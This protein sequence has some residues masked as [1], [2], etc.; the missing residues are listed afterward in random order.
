M[1]LLL[2]TEWGS[3]SGLKADPAPA[4]RSSPT[5]AGPKPTAPENANAPTGLSGG[6]T[7]VRAFG[8]PQIP[9]PNPEGVRSK[10]ADGLNSAGKTA[11][12]DVAIVA[13]LFANYVEV[14]RKHPVGA[15]PEITAALAGDNVRGL[16][17]LPP[18]HPAVNR[19]GELVDRWGTPYFFHHVSRE[20]MEIRSAGPD[21]RHFTADDLVWPKTE[22]T[23]TP[24]EI[25]KAEHAR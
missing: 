6:P 4:S 12:D 16:A 7:P 25:A 2:A 22:A 17:P 10:L 11:Q 14:F 20:I 23:S 9:P 1:I 24:A 15:N 5:K 19:A 13:E 21:H 18:D 3:I 8:A